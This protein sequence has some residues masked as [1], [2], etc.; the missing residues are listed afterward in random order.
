ML[1]KE[2]CKIKKKSIRQIAL[3][4]GIP[5]STLNDLINQKT[6]YNRASFG[7]ICAI[8]DELEISIDELRK[9]L[10]EESHTDTEKNPRYS[11]IVRNKRYYIDIEGSGRE[12][13]CKVNPVTTFSIEDIAFWKYRD[14]MTQKKMEE[15]DAIYFNAQ[16]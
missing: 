13:L 12:Y 10:S 16:R 7:M 1:L 3:N 11:I 6:D 4:T 8:A 5:Y 2:Y 9:M 15:L 14:H